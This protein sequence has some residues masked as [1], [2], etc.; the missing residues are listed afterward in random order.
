MIINNFLLKPNCK[1]F[2][3]QKFK[4]IFKIRLVFAQI[5]CCMYLSMVVESLREKVPC[6]DNGKFYRNPNREAAHVWSATICAK[7]Y[8]CIENEIFSFT[9]STG[10]NFD[11]NR[12]I[13]D[14]KVICNIIYIWY[15]L[16]Y[17]FI[18]SEI[19][20]HRSYYKF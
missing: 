17:N 8:L 10:L 2:R 15:L 16:D 18:P 14:F 11:V 20:L 19:F 6:I 1:I 12:Q 4:M 7:Y 3:T 9:C 5:V 13:C